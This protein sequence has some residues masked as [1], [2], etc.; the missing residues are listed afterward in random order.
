MIEI[1]RFR[2][3]WTVRYVGV[4]DPLHTELRFDALLWVHQGQE[5]VSVITL[6]LSVD[7]GQDW[8]VW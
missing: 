6:Q 8:G 3:P 2:R 4:T 7:L 1:E 5:F